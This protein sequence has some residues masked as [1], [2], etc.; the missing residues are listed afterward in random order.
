MNV[1]KALFMLTKLK[2][3]ISNKSEPYQISEDLHSPKL[4][5]YYFLFHE[6]PS[7]LN[8]LISGFDERG[9][10]VNSAYIDVKDGKPHYYPIS[11]GQYALAVFN[12]Y[13][14][15][16]SEEKKNHFLRIAEWFDETKIETEN[17]GVFWLTDIPKPEYKVDKPW[18]SAF[19]QSRAISTL[20]RAWQITNNQ[21]YLSIA[22]KALIPF[23]ISNKE[24]G[25]SA[26]TKHGKFYEEYVAVE[27]TMVLDGHMFSLLGLYDYYRAVPGDIDG[28]GN[29][30]AKDLF[31]E[32]IESLIR[33]LPEYDMGYWLRF[34]MC[35]MQHYP[36]IDPCTIGYLRL[37]ILQLKLLYKITERQE[38]KDFIN[39]F[40]SYDKLPNI[41][42]M[43]PV[44]YKALK[45]LNRL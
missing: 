42:R 15:S 8:K 24:D 7:K 31:D 14:S 33:W 41:L 22:T 16:N 29:K 39:K 18:K 23:T 38:L 12:S 2:N 5:E 34:N 3:D 36:E 44:K 27:P 35:K 43:Y 26:F 32:G 37:A 13:S 30:L 17:T 28:Y 21:N 25:V 40:E 45:K 9:I 19:T 4:G 1:K 20:L 11:I 10:P 6:D